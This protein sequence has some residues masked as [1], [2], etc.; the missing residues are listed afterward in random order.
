MRLDHVSQNLGMIDIQYSCE[1]IH[2]VRVI[3]T[4]ILHYIATLSLIDSVTSGTLH[5][6]ID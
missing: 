4:I 6:V 5:Y 1:S 3:I 2:V